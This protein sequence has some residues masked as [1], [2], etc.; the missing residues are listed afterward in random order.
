MLTSIKKLLLFLVTLLLCLNDGNMQ[1]NVGESSVIEKW[2][3]M[4]MRT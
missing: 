3:K 1:K 4:N 2:L